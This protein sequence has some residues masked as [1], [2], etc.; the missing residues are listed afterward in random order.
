[1]LEVLVALVLLVILCTALYG[2]YFAV[3]QGRDVANRQMER[4]RELRGTMD[5]V[6]RELTGTLYNR[7]NPRLHFVVEDRDYF[8]KP[9]STLDFTY[10][11]PPLSISLPASDQVR[12]AY[13]AG[14]QEGKILLTREAKDIYAA[15]DPIPY[16][17]MRDLEGFL[18]ECSTDGSTWVRTWNTALNTRL[19]KY[20]RVTLMIKEGEKTV[21]FSTVAIPRIGY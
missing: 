20:I 14:E 7:E 18:V 21:G 13:R 4:Q 19:P 11:A 12:A 15:A 6:R 9:A 16:P 5:Q 8:G 2:S 17:Q 10:I 1:M 3:V